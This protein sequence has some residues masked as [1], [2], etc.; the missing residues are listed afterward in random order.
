MNDVQYVR[1]IRTR[2]W[3]CH[4][5]VWHDGLIRV[6]MVTILPLQYS[7]EKALKLLTKVGYKERCIFKHAY[8]LGRKELEIL[9]TLMMP[10]MS[11]GLP[12]LYQAMDAL[13]EEVS[14][15]LSVQ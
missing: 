7:R 10:G 13:Q 2:L 5:I 4:V 8:W 14:R 6:Q 9:K 1:P 3:S 12:E 15:A 11:E